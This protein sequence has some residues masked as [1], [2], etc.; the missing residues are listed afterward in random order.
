MAFAES[1]AERMWGG[2]AA[3]DGIGSGLLVRGDCA[4]QL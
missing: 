3:G 1:F 2:F 4:D